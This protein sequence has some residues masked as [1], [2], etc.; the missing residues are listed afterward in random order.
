MA[1]HLELEPV[2]TRDRETHGRIL[3]ANAGLGG[4]LAAIRALLRDPD[5]HVTCRSKRRQ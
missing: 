4:V 5:L 1:G 3:A 2:Q